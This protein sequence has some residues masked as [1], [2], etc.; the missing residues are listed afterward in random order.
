MFLTDPTQ[1]PNFL[2]CNF[3]VFAY[4]LGDQIG[5]KVDSITPST[6]RLDGAL[7]LES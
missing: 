5:G 1:D 7:Q 4:I 2:V 3:I 6:A